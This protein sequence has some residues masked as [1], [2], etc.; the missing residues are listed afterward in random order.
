MSSGGVGTSPNAWQIAGDLRLRQRP[1]RSGVLEYGYVVLPIKQLI[2]FSTVGR[3]ICTSLGMIGSR[4][5]LGTHFLR[6]HEDSQE[7]I[8][9]RMF[10][11]DP[12]RKFTVL[13]AS[14]GL[15]DPRLAKLVETI[16][17]E[18]GGRVPDVVSIPT[19]PDMDFAKWYADGI[20]Q[21]TCRSSI[22]TGETVYHVAIP[23]T[24]YERIGTAEQLAET[25]PITAT[26]FIQ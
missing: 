23:G 1:G 26:H 13:V 11:D 21:L 15:N 19:N 6:G 3:I 17:S 10:V 8:V 7:A 25:E 22:D 18:A 24:D 20:G 2:M 16:T 12:A 5:F 9:G 4:E 14:L